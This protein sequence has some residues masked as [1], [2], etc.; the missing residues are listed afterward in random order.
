MPGDISEST[1]YLPLHFDEQP[2]AG[3]IPDEEMLIFSG[4]IPNAVGQG[5]LAV[6]FKGDNANPREYFNIFNGA[7]WLGRTD[8]S[9]PSGSCSDTVVSIITLTDAQI[10]AVA[11]SGAAS[12]RQF[13]IPIRGHP[14]ILTL[15]IRVLH[16]IQTEPMV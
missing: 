4:L 2:D 9:Q 5:V 7:T 10:N 11:Q 13:R 14:S 16:P 12:F 1:S 8:L 6:R 15:S 3:V